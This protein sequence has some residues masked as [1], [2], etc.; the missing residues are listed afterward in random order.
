MLSLLFRPHV[1]YAYVNERSFINEAHSTL[2]A[3]PYAIFLG[4]LM[5]IPDTKLSGCEVRT[6]DALFV[7]L[8]RVL[9]TSRAR[10]RR[11][12]HCVP[13]SFDLSGEPSEQWI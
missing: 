12:R 8:R 5:A 6:A 9:L 1:N 2:M 13:G 11:C 3:T 7:T 10:G 4:T